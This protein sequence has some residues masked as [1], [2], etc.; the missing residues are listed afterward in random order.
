[1]QIR[2][3][4]NKKKKKRK[5]QSAHSASVDVAQRLK[6]EILKLDSI[7][8]FTSQKKQTRKTTHICDE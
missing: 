8:F 6:K 2:Y 3:Q 7:F 4:R 5:I 1:M